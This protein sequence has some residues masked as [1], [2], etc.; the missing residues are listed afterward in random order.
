MQRF[1][2]AAALLNSV[3]QGTQCCLSTH[4]LALFSCAF[5]FSLIFFL[6]MFSSFQSRRFTL[7]LLN[8]FLNVLLI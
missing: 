2:L 5:C 1:P 6:V 7:V 8:L 3:D 4:E